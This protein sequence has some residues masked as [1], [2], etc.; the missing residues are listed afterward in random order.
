MHEWCS[1]ALEQQQKTTNKNQLISHFRAYPRPLFLLLLFL[2]IPIIVIVI[3]P[4]SSSSLSLLLMYLLLLFLLILALLFIL[5]YGFVRERNSR[6]QCQTKCLASQ[7]CRIYWTF[8]VPFLE[9]A[10][11]PTSQWEA[12][13]YEVHYSVF[14][15]RFFYSWKAVGSMRTAEVEVEHKAEQD[16]V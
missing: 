8:I 3:P 16:W 7:Y 15:T 5:T 11:C 6:S 1:A 4:Q 9:I 13:L 14:D 12:I 10:K 2:L